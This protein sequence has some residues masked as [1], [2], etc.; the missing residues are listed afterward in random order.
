M[1]KKDKQRELRELVIQAFSDAKTKGKPD[2]RTM[3]LS[4][5]K[6]RLLQR[7]N[8]GFRE[9]DY[10]VTTL[11]QL[12]E[13]LPDLLVLE[14]GFPP[15]VFHPGRRG[16]REASKTRRM[17]RRSLSGR[18]NPSRRK[19][20]YRFRDL[21]DRYRSI[22]DNLG[23]GEAY[24]SQLPS[25]AP[26]DIDRTFVN[27]VSLWAASNPV[28]A[29]IHNIRDLVQNVDK[30]VPDLLALAVVHAT[31]RT[32]SAGRRPPTKVGDVN[33][34]VADYLR[35]LLDLSPKASPGRDDAR[36][37]GH[38]EGTPVGAGKID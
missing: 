4:V 13:L 5:L 10:G 37:N 23:V 22:G 21:L 15:S 34:R 25:V 29:E 19:M 35:S 14:A 17:G 1:S 6:N 9:A 3:A 36:G 33:Y 27:I 30:F 16:R 12:V 32:Q 7:T 11:R 28:D 26:A 2:W 38:D 8:R 24:A 18:M 20:P 31:L